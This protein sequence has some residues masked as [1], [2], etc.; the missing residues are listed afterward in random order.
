MSDDLMPS[1]DVK[2]K[3]YVR[4][5]GFACQASISDDDLEQESE[6]RIGGTYVHFNDLIGIQ[7]LDTVGRAVLQGV[8]G[9]SYACSKLAGSARECKR[10]GREAKIVWSG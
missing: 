6:Q 9:Q 7:N 1:L 4:A 3:D 2:D 8:L 5:E 10:K